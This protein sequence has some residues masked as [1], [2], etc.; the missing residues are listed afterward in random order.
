MRKNL[1]VTLIAIVVMLS[2]CQQSKEDYIK[3]IKSFVEEVSEECSDYTETE[4]ADVS[5]EFEALVKKAEEY[6]DL[7]VEET[8]ELAAVQAKYAG[9]QAKKGIDKVID[10]VKDLFGD[11]KD[12]E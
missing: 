7:T 4:W 5:N 2:A 12:K 10:G 8:M 1:Y 6:K 9:L 3:E 11:K